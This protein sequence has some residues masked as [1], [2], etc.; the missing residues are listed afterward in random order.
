MSQARESA[1]S[2][3]G[4]AVRISAARCDYLYSAVFPVVTVRRTY[5]TLRLFTHSASRVPLPID[6]LRSDHLLSIACPDSPSRGFFPS[7]LFTGGRWSSLP[8]ARAVG[9]VRRHKVVRS[10]S[11]PQ[12]ESSSS[13]SGVLR[14]GRPSRASPPLRWDISNRRYYL[15]CFMFH[16]CQLDDS[17][18]PT[19]NPE[20]WSLKNGP[21]AALAS[22]P[23]YIQLPTPNTVGCP[24]KAERSI[25]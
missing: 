24:T 7:D 20:T 9:L 14:R 6:C 19:R 4:N 18:G 12:E 15:G 1:S 11:I 21:V 3:L 10:S 22:L 16:V 5:D 2:G 8:R 13:E 23:N 25:S 17:V